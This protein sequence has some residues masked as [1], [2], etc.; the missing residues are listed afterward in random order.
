MRQCAQCGLPRGQ[1]KGGF[2][3]EQ[4]KIG[5][6]AILGFAPATPP[7]S[8]PGGSASPLVPLGAASPPRMP[9]ATLGVHLHPYGNKGV[10][11]I[12]TIRLEN[13]SGPHVRQHL[14]PS[15]DKSGRPF[16]KDGPPGSH[17]KLWSEPRWDRP[18]SAAAAVRLRVHAPAVVTE[19]LLPPS[20]TESF[21]DGAGSPIDRGSPR[22]ASPLPTQQ[23]SS[24]SGGTSA[25]GTKPKRRVQSARPG[26]TGAMSQRQ[27]ETYEAHRAAH[28]KV[29]QRL[30][31]NQAQAAV[32]DEA[33]FNMRWENVCEGE[34]GIVSEVNDYLELRDI[35][36]RRKQTA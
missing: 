17:R 10:D 21:A 7:C 14:H 12:E 11:L 30:R 4:R 8:W 32:K 31:L 24:A 19:L 16:R 6:R 33:D 15:V 5:V 9:A 20:H 18:Q 36:S 27:R 2:A 13:L 35:E 3:C 29:M 28:E 22:A 23:H 25:G 34:F 26:G 1:G